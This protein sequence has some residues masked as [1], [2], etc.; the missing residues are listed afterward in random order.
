[1]HMHHLSK[2][3]LQNVCNPFSPCASKSFLELPLLIN[4]KQLYLFHQLFSPD[5]APLPVH[6]ILYYKLNYNLYTH[7]FCSKPA[8]FSGLSLYFLHSGHCFNNKSAG[9]SF[10]SS[11]LSLNL[12]ISLSTLT[13]SIALLHDSPLLCFWR[14]YQHKY[15]SYNM[16][17]KKFFFWWPIADSPLCSHWDNTKA[18]N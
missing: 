2:S 10:S 14:T 18:L 3:I 8:S 13:A 4:A 7:T 16:K 1:M 17:S 6:L 5:I 11:P 15:C 9:S 12:W